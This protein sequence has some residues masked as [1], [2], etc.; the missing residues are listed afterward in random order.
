MLGSDEKTLFLSRKEALAPKSS[1]S[2]A[3]RPAEAAE[4]CAAV[5]AAVRALPVV[6]E[7][8]GGQFG[9]ALEAEAG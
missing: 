3:V 8:E 9:A 7:Q 5:D 2:T 4:G 1:S 6:A